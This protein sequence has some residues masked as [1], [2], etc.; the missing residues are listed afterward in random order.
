[1]SHYVTYILSSNTTVGSKILGQAYII[2]I[3]S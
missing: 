3:I 2:F 1:L